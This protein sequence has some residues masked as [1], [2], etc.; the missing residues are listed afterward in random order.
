M[1]QVENCSVSPECEAP[2]HLR[3]ALPSPFPH[4]QA[5]VFPHLLL[6]AASEVQKPP[7]S[8]ADCAPLRR[9]SSLP[10]AASRESL[11]QTRSLPPKASSLE[12]WE[13]PEATGGSRQMESTVAHG[14]VVKTMGS[15]RCSRC[16]DKRRWRRQTAPGR[17][18][19]TADFL[20][21]LPSPESD[22]SPAVKSIA[23]QPA[24]DFRRARCRPRGVMPRRMRAGRSKS[25]PAAGTSTMGTTGVRSSMSQSA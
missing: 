19:S 12:T 17:L 5:T 16:S 6:A 10:P 25:Q 7:G 18:W 2:S 20:R 3:P 11:S 23:S 1:T 24:S 14:R 22:K 13:G 8:S 9:P 4:A 21:L 15:Q